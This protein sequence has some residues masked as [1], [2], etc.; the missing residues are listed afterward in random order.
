VDGVIEILD[1]DGPAV[2]GLE[3]TFY[4]VSEGVGVVEVCAIVYSPSG[5]CPIAIPFDVALSTQDGTGP[6]RAVTPMDYGAVSTI[7][8]FDACDTRQCEDVPILHVT[9][10]SVWMYQSWMMRHWS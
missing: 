3:R 8:M 10:D 5:I 6:N 7:L 4:Q 9:L 2:V 1:N